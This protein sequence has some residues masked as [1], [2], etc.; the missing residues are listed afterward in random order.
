MPENELKLHAWQDCIA[1]PWF[2]DPAALERPI[3][4]EGPASWRRSRDPE[5]ARTLVT[6]DLPDVEVSRVREGDDSVSFRVS[7]TGVPVWVKVSWFPN[8]EA[9][10]AR[11][12][13]RA[14]PNYMVVVPTDRDV[15]LRYGTTTAEWVGR[16]GTLLGIGGVVA[17]VVVPWRRRAPRQRVST[18]RDRGLR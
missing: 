4:A 13:Y 1:A 6:P 11:G 9:E 5:R 12:P 15:T 18:G 17:L 3:V 14:T 2:D 16:L 10:G 8:W 7:R